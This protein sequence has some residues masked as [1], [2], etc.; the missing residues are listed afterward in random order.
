M[1]SIN[2]S[3]C[4]RWSVVKDTEILAHP[5]VVTK[6]GGDICFNLHFMGNPLNWNVLGWIQITGLVMWI[7][8]FK[9]GKLSNWESQNQQFLPFLLVS[10]SYFWGYFSCFT[11]FVRYASKENKIWAPRI[12]C[13]EVP[14]PSGGALTFSCRRFPASSHGSC[15]P[16][17][18]EGSRL[19]DAGQKHLESTRIGK[20]CVEGFLQSA[21]SD[22]NTKCTDFTHTQE[23]MLKYTVER[24]MS[25][26]LWFGSDFSSNLQDVC[27]LSHLLFWRLIWSN[28]HAMGILVS[29]WNT[30][31]QPPQACISSW[32][33]TSGGGCQR[34]R[35]LFSGQERVLE[36]KS[37]VCRMD[38]SWIWARVYSVAAGGHALSAVLKIMPSTYFEMLNNA[39]FQYLVQNGKN[40]RANG[41][42]LLEN[43]CFS[44]SASFCLSLGLP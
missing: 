9:I 25:Q 30:K 37:Y 42:W 27:Q 16:K 22:S 23:K 34:S 35:F 8:E 12:K 2:S 24:S 28:R 29:F 1:F 31:Q 5:R 21:L 26:P 19:G 43:V 44:S 3:F 10:R 17:H 39:K 40:S 41:I 14:Q 20:H 7:P 32:F 11:L 18:M 13:G 15:R 6:D 36:I 4:R 38:T 33:W